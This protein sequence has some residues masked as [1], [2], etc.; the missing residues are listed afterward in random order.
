[1]QCSLSSSTAEWLCQN[2]PFNRT[3][4]KRIGRITPG[5]LVFREDT[6]QEDGL[7]G[8]NLD[9]SRVNRVNVNPGHDN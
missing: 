8:C 1:M 5:T 7:G 2:F 6:V 9:S 3:K 4:T